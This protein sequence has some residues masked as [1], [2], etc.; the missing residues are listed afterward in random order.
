MTLRD[1]RYQG[2]IL[3]DGGRILLLLHRDA[4]TSHTFWLIPGGGREVGETEEECVLREMR[5][6]TCLDVRIE[7]LLL[8]EA[9]TRGGLYRRIKTYLCRAQAGS[10]P[11]AGYEPI[12]GTDAV[13]PIAAVGWWSLADEATWDER[14]V[15]DPITSGM[16][17]RIRHALGAQSTT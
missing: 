8:D 15:R 14:I 10:V 16:L 1:T 6:E 5:E 7:R 9:G 4:A 2:A 17:R 12:E 3:D 13:H 11:A